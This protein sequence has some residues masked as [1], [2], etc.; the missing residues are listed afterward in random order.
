[1]AFT[2]RASIA[3]TKLYSGYAC[4]TLSRGPLVAQREV[5]EGLY[6]DN[7]FDNSLDFECLHVRVSESFHLDGD[8]HQ[9]T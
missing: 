2:L 9:E 7:S 5:G 6:F 4:E 3:A 1:M 8:F